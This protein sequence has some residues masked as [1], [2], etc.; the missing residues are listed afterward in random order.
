[1]A[2]ALL[3]KVEWK[4]RKPYDAPN[5]VPVDRPVRLGELS[6]AGMLTVPGRNPWPIDLRLRVPPDLSRWRT[7]T[8][9][10][11][12]RYRY[13]GYG[14]P[15]NSSLSV[16]LNEELIKRL[17]LDEQAETAVKR[18]IG[19]EPG[20]VREKIRIPLYA[21]ASDASLQFKFHYEHTRE[22]E[23]SGTLVD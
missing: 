14:V 9:P 22:N 5:W 18:V 17:D 12:L 8:I 23:C 2:V 3:T 1:G 11:D 15:H 7:E 16:L 20:A 6:P 19:G 10:L 21:F 4:P 13:A